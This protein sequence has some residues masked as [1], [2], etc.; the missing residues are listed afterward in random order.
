M[1]EKI[2]LRW[3]TYEVAPEDS[4]YALGVVS[5]NYTR[6]ERTHVWMLAA[7]A[8]MTED[9]AAI[10]TAR[11]NASE[12]AKLIE[13]FFDRREWPSETAA[14]IKHYLKAMGVLIQSRNVLIH[15]NMVRGTENRTAIYSLSKQGRHSLFQANLKEIRAVADGLETYFNFGLGL[16][17]YIATEIHHMD[18]EAGTLVVSQLP[19]LPSLP[20][21]IDPNQRPKKK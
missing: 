3:P 14:A 9:Q 13:T 1:T 16:A 12:R 15:S 7:V 5:I 19:C 2:T 4:V 10:I 20:A 8:N 6:F 21:H 18:R 11:T 17:N